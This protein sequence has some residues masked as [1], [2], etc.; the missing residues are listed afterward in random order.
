MD[1]KFDS[2]FWMGV[3]IG[4]LVTTIVILGISHIAYILLL[5]QC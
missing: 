5:T 1:K 4:V 2:N 3:F